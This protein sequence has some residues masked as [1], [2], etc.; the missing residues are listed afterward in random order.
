[1]RVPQISQL[2]LGFYYY[3]R[4]HS[5]SGQL[6]C[7]L[8]PV[9]FDVS[10]SLQNPT[11][12]REVQQHVYNIPLVLLYNNTLRIPRLRFPDSDAHKLNTKCFSLMHQL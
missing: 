2:S 3:L 1:M 10:S 11:R 5:T 6:V 7:M 9:K 4:V 8:T 12:Y